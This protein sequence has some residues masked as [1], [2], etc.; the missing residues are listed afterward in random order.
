MNMIQLKYQIAFVVLY[1]VAHTET[2]PQELDNEIPDDAII[3]SR[4]GKHNVCGTINSSQNCSVAEEK[5]NVT[6]RLDTEFG[7]WP[8]MCAILK[9]R[10]L[11]GKII[12][13][14][15]AGASLITPGVLIT[16]AHW[17]K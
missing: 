6:G 8:H 1:C 7:E 10:N 9:K 2:R 14:F 13:E 11:N 4:C 17:V 16:A 15:W 3:K 5:N 12:Q